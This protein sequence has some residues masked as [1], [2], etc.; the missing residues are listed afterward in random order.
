MGLYY[1]DM[2]ERLF[3]PRDLRI[4]V[5][6]WHLEARL[7]WLSDALLWKDKDTNRETAS[8]YLK[9]APT[10][11]QKLQLT[12]LGWFYEREEESGGYAYRW[13]FNPEGQYPEEELIC[14][15]SSEQPKA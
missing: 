14:E 13:H 5:R 15:V 1:I 11:E 8:F 10:A 3:L 4:P 2:N 9:G 12:S 6:V 7:P